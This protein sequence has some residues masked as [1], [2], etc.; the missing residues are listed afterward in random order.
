MWTCVCIYVVTPGF[1]IPFAKTHRA[2]GPFWTFWGAEDS[3]WPAA[4][5]QP[6]DC[7]PWRVPRRVPQM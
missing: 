3:H 1:S 4:F 5:E 6:D 2:I 7:C